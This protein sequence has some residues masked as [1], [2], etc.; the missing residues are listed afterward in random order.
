MNKYDAPPTLLVSD[1]SVLDPEEHDPNA[2]IETTPAR[3]LLFNGEDAGW[4]LRDYAADR[5][6]PFHSRTAAVRGM[7]LRRGR[8][9]D[10]LGSPCGINAYGEPLENVEAFA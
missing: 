6:Y 8:N 3:F 4:V 5:D 9:E 1:L 10:F 2:L 7:D